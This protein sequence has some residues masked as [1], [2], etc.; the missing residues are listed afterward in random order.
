[1]NVVEILG[2]MKEFFAVLGG[3]L[4]ATL[5]AVVQSRL[6]NVQ[7][8]AKLRL[9]KLERAYALCQLVYDGH[10][11]ELNNFKKHGISDAEEFLK[12]RKH[13]GAEMSELKMLVR[14]YIPKLE[15]DLQALDKG[16]GPLK[17]MFAKLEVDARLSEPLPMDVFQRECAE[18]ESHLQVFEQASVTLKQKIA[19]EAR[20]YT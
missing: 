10:L 20:K 11:R 3:A 2:A 1:M 17:Q 14:C 5:G 19:A 6:A 7:A 9:E 18:A 12:L 4:A 15:S 16:H 8:K 13:P